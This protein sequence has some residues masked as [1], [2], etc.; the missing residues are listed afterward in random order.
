MPTKK[1]KATDKTTTTEEWVR[2]RIFV[3]QSHAFWIRTEL[4]RLDVGRI[5]K[6]YAVRYEYDVSENWGIHF[7]H[8]GPIYSGLSG[9]EGP[10]RRQ[11]GH[12]WV[13][14]APCSIR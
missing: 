4:D 10:T 13:A 3:P 11:Q 12:A 1:P 2:L 8:V 6:Y 5:G 14:A 7:A 9:A